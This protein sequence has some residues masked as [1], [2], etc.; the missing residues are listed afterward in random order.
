[1]G[2][3]FLVHEGRLHESLTVVEDAIDLHGSDVLTEGRKL[4]LLNGRHLALGIED[5]DMDAVHAEETI[6]H[7]GAGV[8]RGGY[9]DVDGRPTP[10]PSRQGG[11][12]LRA[13]LERS[14]ALAL[15]GERGEGPPQQPRHKPSADILE[16]KCGA[17]EEFEGIDVVLNLHD[18]TVEGEGVI[19]NAAQVVSGDILAE[20]GICHAVGDLLEGEVGHL[21]PECVR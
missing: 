17:M 14:K 20:E 11:V 4:A 19:D 2:I 5:I 12:R 9:E 8:A 1:M 3:K 6:G 10:A 18:G 16:G 15:T 7:G 21:C 13:T